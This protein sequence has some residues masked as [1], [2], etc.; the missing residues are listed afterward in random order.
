MRQ[1]IRLR[2]RR[3][4]CPGCR[5]WLVREW[6]GHLASVFRMPP[7]DIWTGPEAGDMPLPRCYWRGWA[8]GCDKITKYIARHRG[9]YVRISLAHGR[10]LIIATVP[11]PKGKRLDINATAEMVQTIAAIEVPKKKPDR[12]VP[13][14]TSTGW[15]PPPSPKTGEHTATGWTNCRDDSHRVLRALGVDV[16]EDLPRRDPP[17]HRWAYPS[18]WTEEQSQWA[19]YW[20]MTGILPDGFKTGDLPPDPGPT[21]AASASIDPPPDD[22]EALPAE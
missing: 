15:R 8:K 9:Q 6:A 5:T 11:F 22:W 19:D 13:I 21:L 1:G 16:V 10:A 12:F 7:W 4:T 2:C 14:V 18:H 3:W 20:A 17:R